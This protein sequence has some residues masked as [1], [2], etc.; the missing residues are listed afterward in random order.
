MEKLMSRAED[1]P[2]RGAAAPLGSKG[3]GS[4]PGNGKRA[5]DHRYAPGMGWFR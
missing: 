2:K 4:V 3:A 5:P 1:A